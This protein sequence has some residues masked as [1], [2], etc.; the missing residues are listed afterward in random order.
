VTSTSDISTEVESIS[1]VIRHARG[2]LD[3]EGL[4]DVSPIERRVNKLCGR[5]GKLQAKDG[6]AFQPRILALID[7]F[8][9]LGTMIESRLES[10]RGGLE[11]S[12]GRAQAL[13]A[14]GRAVHSDKPKS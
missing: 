3:T 2:V 6:A 14:Y 12:G 9:E 1:A 13:S 10:L 5:L 4:I 11:R 8:G 7:E